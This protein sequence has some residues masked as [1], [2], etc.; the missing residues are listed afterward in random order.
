ML[1]ARLTQPQQFV[2]LQAQSPARM[3]EAV[4]HREP[5]IRLDLRP[6]H[7]LHKEVSKIELLELLRLRSRLR[8]DE[9]ELVSRMHDK[10][11]TGLGT[12]T[13]PIDALRNCPRAVGF[14]G[15]FIAAS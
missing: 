6:I 2:R 10:I 1:A 8:I 13:E 3:A 14:H 9:L 15:D 4:L 7:R 11:R 5:R 12:D